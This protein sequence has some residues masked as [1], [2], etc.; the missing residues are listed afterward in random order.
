MADAPKRILI[1]DD[2][3]ALVDVLREYIDTR[4]AQKSY[5]VETAAN[6][7]DGLRVV[8]G[9]R[10][11]LVILDIEMPEMNGVEVLKQIREID[12]R[13]PVIMLTGTSDM[14]ATAATL[15]HGAVSYAPKP[16][17]LQ[18]LDHLLAM[19]LPKPRGP[20]GPPRL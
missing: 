7:P 20:S 15:E 4:F 5:V 6:G 13:I 18:Y 9:R 3:A 12:R 1:I 2:D 10:P 8:R 17:N 16:L 19:Y 14:S 11:D